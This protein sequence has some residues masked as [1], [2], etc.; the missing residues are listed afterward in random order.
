MP[1]RS[2]GTSSGVNVQSEETK[3]TDIKNPIQKKHGRTKNPFPKTS[4][5]HMVV[6][7]N[8]QINPESREC[9][10]LAQTLKQTTDQWRDPNVI[11][12][13]L[14]FLD[15]QGSFSNQ[16][17]GE[18][19]TKATVERGPR[20]NQ[21]HVHVMVMTQ[22]NTKL[23]LN[24]EKLRD[25]YNEALGYDGKEKKVYL[26]VRSAGK[27]SFEQVVTNYIEKNM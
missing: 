26:Y 11:G 6:N 7:S 2:K 14:K 9:E 5:F 21:P 12:N 18:I 1:R 15:G 19:K 25:L 24:T 8:F 4:N 13:Y 3:V 22:H 27:Q 17:I 16:Y 23:H 20:F 10:D